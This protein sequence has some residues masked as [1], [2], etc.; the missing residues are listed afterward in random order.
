MTTRNAAITVVEYGIQPLNGRTIL[1]VTEDFNEAAD[2]LDRLGS[3]TLVQ[4]TIRYGPWRNV[5]ARL[6]AAV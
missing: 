6:S 5:K 1:M 3:G 4:H 2:I